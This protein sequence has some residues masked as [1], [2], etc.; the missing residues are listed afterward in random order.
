MYVHNYMCVNLV[1]EGFELAATEHTSQ[2]PANI[3]DSDKYYV[4]MG[5]ETGTRQANNTVVGHKVSI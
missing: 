5:L 2:E 1:S 3:T 4:I